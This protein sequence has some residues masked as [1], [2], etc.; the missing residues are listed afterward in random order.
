MNTCSCCKKT[1][2]THLLLKS[3]VY[4]KAFYH[5]CVN[6]TSSETRLINS[7]KSVNWTCQKCDQL[8]NDI[9]SLKAAI[10]A[11]QNEIRNIKPVENVTLNNIQFEEIVQ[12]VSE[13]QSRQ[14]NL[15]IF[16]MKEQSSAI[17]K[18]ERISSEKMEVSKLIS[19]VSLGADAQ[20]TNMHR[21]GKFDK[22]RSSPRPIKITLNSREIAL[23]LIRK[24][25]S[26][27]N[28]TFKQISLSFDK[29]PKQLEYYKQLKL[30]LEE[31]KNN[32]ET[33]VK[34]KYFNGVPK[35]INF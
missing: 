12:E 13:R 26:L 23:E 7:K 8:G 31:R 21:L 18:D 34:I 20:I 16:G 10:V 24:S 33:N 27:K 3:C 30:E 29:T 25:P 14:R 28:S 19:Y 1:V 17:S 6:I 32:G 5:S 9:N 22:D 35:I 11:L 2:E 15:L 4:Q